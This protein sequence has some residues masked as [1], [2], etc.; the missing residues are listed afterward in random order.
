MSENASGGLAKTNAQ[1]LFG[2]L[3]CMLGGFSAVSVFLAMEGQESKNLLARPVEGA[4]TIFG[5]PGALVVAAGLAL[6][7][8]ILFL[9]RR[10]IAPLRHLVGVFALGLG[11]SLVVGGVRPSLA[12]LL[13]SALPEALPGIAGQVACFAIGVTVLVA[14]I[15]VV[16][17]ARLGAPLAGGRAGAGGSKPTDFTE[18]LKPGTAERQSDGVSVAEARALQGLKPGGASARSSASEGSSGPFSH[19]TKAKPIDVPLSTRPQAIAPPGAS[20]PLS[21]PIVRP[22]APAP[23]GNAPL[24]DVAAKRTASPV[25]PALERRSNDRRQDEK[26]AAG[27]PLEAPVLPLPSWESGEEDAEAEELA[28]AELDVP[29]DLGA[30]LDQDELDLEAELLANALEVEDEPEVADEER[31][32]LPIAVDLDTDEAE[33]ELERSLVLEEGLDEPIADALDR[34]GVSDEDLEALED[35]AEPDAA[36]AS[37]EGEPAA[38][39]RAAS[40]RWEQV[41]LFDEEAEVEHEPPVPAETAQAT[42]EP[43]APAVAASREDPEPAYVLTP[44]PERRAEPRPAAAARAD[45]AAPELDTLTYEAGRLVLEQNRVAVSMLQK[46]FSLDFDQACGVLDRLQAAGLIGPYVGGRSREILLSIEEWESVAH[47]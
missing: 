19:V 22:R 16:W 45:A 26:A 43:A 25:L 20:K 29:G 18:I 46:R 41:G 3:A 44:A 12:G 39:A 10:A 21:D 36:V 31:E 9:A 27:S 15:W 34:I 6:F 32:V 23:V 11:V 1:D 37:S 7:G 38:D 4:M 5:S 33:E 47:A 28:T 42:S 14:T 35:A 8:T 13:G 2:I 40:A 17:L 30:V 24:P